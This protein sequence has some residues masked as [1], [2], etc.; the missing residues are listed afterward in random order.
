LEKASPIKHSANRTS[1]VR[2]TRRAPNRIARKP[3]RGPANTTT[4]V[5]TVMPAMI[6]PID[7]PKL[8][9]RKGARMPVV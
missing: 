8:F 9:I 2:A 5:V 1:D 6:W 7:H 3:T 4:A